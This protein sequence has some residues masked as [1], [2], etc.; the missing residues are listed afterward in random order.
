M[1]LNGRWLAWHVQGPGFYLSVCPSVYLCLSVSLSL[2][3]T[4]TH[5]NVT[6]NFY[7]CGIVSENKYFMK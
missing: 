2:S 3:H 7:I 4:Q 1:S 5:K 6:Y